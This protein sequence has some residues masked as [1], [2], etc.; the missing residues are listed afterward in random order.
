MAR[1]SSRIQWGLPIFPLRIDR[2]TNPKQD[3]RGTS[4]ARPSGHMQRSPAAI[5]RQ[6]GPG[7]L[8]K[9]DLGDAGMSGPGSFVQRST[10]VARCRVDRNTTIEQG[11]CHPNVASPS[12]L[13]QRSPAFKGVVH[14]G[15]SRLFYSDRPGDPNS[16][17]AFGAG[18]TIICQ[19]LLRRPACLAEPALHSSHPAT[20]HDQASST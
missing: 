3:L 4:V 8:G 11:F 13:V 14:S 17:V 15:F 6:V 9:Q 2:D 10:S 16:F 5:R 19:P 1:P 12:S 20:L 7:T 18:N